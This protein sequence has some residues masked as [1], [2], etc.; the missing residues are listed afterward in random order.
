MFYD[1][2]IK[3]DKIHRTYRTHGGYKK[4]YN[5]LI[6]KIHGNKFLGRLG[7]NG[8]TILKSTLMGNEMKQTC[9]GMGPMVDLCNK[10]FLLKEYVT[11]S[12]AEY[13]V[14]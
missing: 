1:G 10:C 11:I 8:M 2:K 3:K 9:D 5:I 13:Y 7:I 12:P 14:L 4:P 6:V